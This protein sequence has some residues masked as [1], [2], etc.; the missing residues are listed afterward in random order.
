MGLPEDELAYRH[1]V[2]RVRGVFCRPGLLVP[3]DTTLYVLTPAQHFNACLP[4]GPGRLFTPPPQPGGPR[5]VLAFWV[6][7]AGEAGARPL[8]RLALVQ[9]TAALASAAN[10]TAAAGVRA[11]YVLQIELDLLLTRARPLPLDGDGTEEPSE[12]EAAGLARQ[13][14]GMVLLEGGVNEEAITRMWLAVRDERGGFVTCDAP[15]GKRGEL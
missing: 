9:D 10:L 6:R 4:L 14:R 12:A 11:H 1:R 15:T 13:R 5:G 8:T 7:L 2:K 3:S